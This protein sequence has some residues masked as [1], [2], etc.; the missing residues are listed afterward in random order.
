MA[1]RSNLAA[2]PVS[3]L[4]AE[5]RRR[6]RGV[7]SLHKRRAKLLAKLAALDAEIREAGG[8]LAGPG[9][10]SLRKRPKNDMKLEESLVKLLK[11]KTMGVTEAA[12]EV[13]KAGYKTSSTTFRTIVNQ[14]LIKSKKIKKVARGQYTAA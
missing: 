4:Q 14:C 5:L 2:L 9:G 1:R 7:N 3:A 11:G 10:L 12:E 6:S 8:S 13:Q